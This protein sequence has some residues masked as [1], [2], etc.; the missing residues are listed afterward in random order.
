MRQFVSFLFLILLIIS[1][2]GKKKQDSLVTD[3]N[4]EYIYDQLPDSLRPQIQFSH[5]EHNFGTFSNT[6]VK[7]VAFEFKNIGK[8]PLILHNVHGNCGCV[9]VMFTKRPIQPGQNGSIIVTYN[10]REYEKGKFVKEIVVNSNAVNRYFNLQIKG[11][12]K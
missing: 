12:T 8:S 1:C 6:T 9:T 11:E 10:G 2:N 3:K 4:A 7:K 5:A